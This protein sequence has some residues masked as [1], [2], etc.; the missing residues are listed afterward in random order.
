MGIFSKLLK[1]DPLQEQA[2]K[3]V[4]AANVMV[5]SAFVPLLDK[6]PMLREVKVDAWDFYATA[7][8]IFVALNNLKSAV[9]RERFKRIYAIVLPHLHKWHARGEDAVLDCQKFVERTVASG[10]SPQDALGFWVLWNTLGREPA[11][12]EATLGRTI[13]GLLS[14]SLQDWWWE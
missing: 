9:H 10:A 8:A 5:V 3:L 4:P 12:H 14:A 11:E 6:H 2:V 13:G 7:G 1:K